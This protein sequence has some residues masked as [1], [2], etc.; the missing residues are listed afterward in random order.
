M[1]KDIIIYR[2]GDP[3]VRVHPNS[4]LLLTWHRQVPDLGTTF[5]PRS[6]V[7]KLMNVL[8]SDKHFRTVAELSFCYWC[9]K[10]FQPNDV[11]NGDHVPP[12][13]I[14]ANPDR[15][16]PLKLKTHVDCNSEHKLTDEKMGQLLALLHGKVP[17]VENQKLKFSIDRERGLGAVNNTDIEGSVWRYVRG[18]HVA[19]YR[20]P[21]PMPVPLP[22]VLSGALTVPLVKVT[23]D[24]LTDRMKQPQH[25]KIVE[26]IKTQRA[27]GNLDRILSN[28]GK[29]IYECVWVQ[30]SDGRW[31]CMFALD[32]YG[33]KDL[34]DTGMYPA[35]GCAGI[36]IGKAG[37]PPPAASCHKPLAVTVPNLD[38]L[39]PFGR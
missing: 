4:G 34:G 24:D 21:F 38:P 17:A 10:D 23:A 8:L 15:R 20:E 7:A 33:W 13:A 39:D 27:L 37:D 35:R 22:A 18:F 30:A 11:A 2:K 32:I 3:G 28:N 31:T 25:R 9:G 19:L 29:L 5:H 26:V 16:R 14:F 36:Y 6:F 12:K 1:I